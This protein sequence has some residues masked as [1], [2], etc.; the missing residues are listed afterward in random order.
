MD[1]I[2]LSLIFFF[3]WALGPTILQHMGF[4]AI[5]DISTKK[6][7]HLGKL[8]LKPTTSTSNGKHQLLTP[9]A[10]SAM[11]AR[12]LMLIPIFATHFLQTRFNQAR[13]PCGLNSCIIFYFILFKHGPSSCDLLGEIEEV[14]FGGYGL[15]SFWPFAWAQ[16]MRATKWARDTGSISGSWRRSCI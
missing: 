8:I 14:W 16:P 9:Y 2:D 7:E 12:G 10:A 4:S 13:L 11:H 1:F 5:H 15:V 3:K 6:M